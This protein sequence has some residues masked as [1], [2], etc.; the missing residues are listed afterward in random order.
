MFDPTRPCAIPT[1]RAWLA[2]GLSALASKPARA[3]SPS[4][5]GFGRAKSVLFVFTSGGQSQLETWDPKPNAPA[6][7]RGAFGS[8]PS[9]VPGTRLCEHLPELAKR[10]GKYAIVRSMT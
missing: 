9:A 6:E 7:I 2:F 8:I 3:K 1:R 5:A 10:A 4:A